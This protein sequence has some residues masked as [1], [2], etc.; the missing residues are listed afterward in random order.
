MEIR[1]VVAKILGL[2]PVKELKFELVREAALV[3]E[4]KSELVKEVASVKELKSELVREVAS[5]KKSDKK[6]RI[7]FWTSIILAL[8][9]IFVAVGNSYLVVDLT[10][11]NS[12]MQEGKT[13]VSLLDTAKVDAYSARVLIHNIEESYKSKNNN[14]NLVY[15]ANQWSESGAKLPY[16]EALAMALDD[17]NVRIKLSQT[18]SSNFNDYKEQLANDRNRIMDPNIEPI[19]KAFTYDSYKH[20]LQDLTSFLQEEIKFQKGE[21]SEEGMAR[22]YK[23]LEEKRIKRSEENIKMMEKIVN[24]FEVNSAQ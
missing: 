11:K 9:S 14:Y 4:L 22:F 7:A 12:E 2:K 17:K 24:D 15:M 16:P 21:I 23:V 18:G 19:T 10:Q 6:N 3:K 13:V 1:N 8:L 5:V 20:D